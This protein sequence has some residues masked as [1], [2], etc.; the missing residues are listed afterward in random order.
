ME[1][2]IAVAIII[3]ANFFAVYI[4]LVAAMKSYAKTL[5]AIIEECEKSDD[6]KMFLD[7]WK[8]ASR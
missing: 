5:T 1:I 7:A 6:D 4:A 2:F 8:K 3:A